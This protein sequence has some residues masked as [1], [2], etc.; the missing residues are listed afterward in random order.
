MVKCLRACEEKVPRRPSSR[1][2]KL[3]HLFS[4]KLKRDGF[5]SEYDAKKI[6]YLRSRY[7]V[8]FFLQLQFR[9]IKSISETYVSIVVGR[10]CLCSYEIIFQRKISND[11]QMSSDDSGYYLA[12][13]IGLFFFTA[14]D[15]VNLLLS[16]Q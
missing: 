7:P 11:C 9:E 8:L 13:T 10:S 3:F 15:K 12:F 4:E 16:L 5:L 1:G 2:C 6:M 14:P